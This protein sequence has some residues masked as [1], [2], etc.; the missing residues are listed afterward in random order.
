MSSD[1]YAQESEAA[2]EPPPIYLT[3]LTIKNFKRVSFARLNPTSWEPLVIG[4]ENAQGKSTLMDAVLALMLG[5][6]A[7]PVQPIKL[8]KSKSEIEGYLGDE[9]HPNQYIVKR[10]FSADGGTKLTVEPTDGSKMDVSAQAFLTS[11]AGKSKDA[12]A[13]DPLLL[14]KMGKDEQDAFMRKICRVDFAS[15][16][17]DRKKIYDER[18]LV[19]K[20]HER[21]KHDAEKLV[22]H[23]DAPGRELVML[24][25][26]AELER[27]QKIERAN[28]A[29]IEDVRIEESEI[30]VEAAKLEADDAAI[31]AAETELASLQ[32]RI[33]QLQLNRD[34]RALGVASRRSALPE[35]Q[36]SLDG[37]PEPLVEQARQAIADAE[38]VNVKVRANAA[39]LESVL[40]ANR[41]AERADELTERI[42]VIDA[43][44]AA[45]L[46]NAKYPIEGL[47]FDDIGPTFDGLPLSQAS[48]AQLVKIGVA[49]G[50][51][52]RPRLR[53]LLVRS[54]NDLDSKSKATLWELAKQ[55]RCHVWIEVVSETGE[56]CSIV[57]S[58]G[59]IVGASDE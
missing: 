30:A 52:L 10:K 57:M 55:H 22:H 17:A 29:R 32:A 2:G 5:K 28:A 34:N 58:E 15:L 59:A 56:G 47:G 33:T 49:I 46:E 53:L 18:T 19:N 36:A 27:R 44:K 8:G 7:C 37:L 42:K 54:G 1:N 51:A 48:Q 11:I 6:E 4:G 12:I 14:A 3:Q 23:N 41:V 38:A 16:D 24:D 26:V 21:A 45:V 20:E 25:L 43:R 40:R 50:V 13:F 39:R 35:L 31:A 9:E